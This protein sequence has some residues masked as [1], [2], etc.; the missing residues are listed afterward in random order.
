MVSESLDFVIKKCDNSTREGKTPC[1]D[2]E[3]IDEYLQI[4]EIEAWVIQEKIAF[5]KYDTRPVFILE[6][7]LFQLPLG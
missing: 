7:V 4:L 5:S 6:E 2:E 3:H 1:K